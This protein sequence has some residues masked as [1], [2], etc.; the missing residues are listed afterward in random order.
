MDRTFQPT[1]ANRRATFKSLMLSGVCLAALSSS[2]IGA[3]NAAEQGSATTQSAAT[4]VQ[5]EVTI[6]GSRI[7]QPGMESPVP[8]TSVPAAQLKAMA[9]DTI[10]SGLVQLPE[11]YQSQTPNSTASWFTRGGYGN[12]DL[13]GLGI[14]RTL[15]LLNGRRVVSSTVF[16]G[17]DV[18][19]IP[20]AMISRVETVTGGASAAYGTDAVAGVVNFIL[21]TDYTGM[22]VNAQ[23][24][25][26]SRGDSANY[27]LSATFGTDIGEHAHIQ[28]SA[29]RFHQDGVFNYDGRDWYQAWGTIP[30]S[31]GMLLIR[32]NVISNNATLGGL[33]SA[34]GTVINGLQ[35][36]PDGSYSPLNRGS[37]SFGTAGTPPARSIGGSG[38]NLGGGYQTLYPDFTRQSFFGY[39]DYDV[40]PNLNIYAQYIH[41]EDST[42]RHNTPA[43]SLQG[44]PTQVT[45]F[46]DNAFLPDSL[47]QIMI[48][49]GIASF[50]LHTQ[51]ASPEMNLTDDSKMDSI[52]GGFKYTV[53]HDG[54]FDN[55]IVNGYYQ[56]GHNKRE[57]DQVGFRVD[58]IFAAAD[59]VVDPATGATVCRVS[60]FGNAFPGCQPIN[61]FGQGNASPAALDYV[62]GNDVGEQ[63]TTPLYIAGSGTSLG[64][65]DS[66]SAVEAKVNRT[67]LTQNVAELSASGTVLEGW[68]GPISA[69]FGGSYR[70]EH[71]L[72]TVRDSTNQ[73]SNFDTGHP[74]LCSGEAPGL[75]G[76][77]PP[78]CANTVGIQYSKVSNIIGTISVKELFA[79]TQI[80]LLESSGIIES[81][82][83]NLAGRWARYSGSGS[84]WAYKGGLDVQFMGGLRLRGTYSRDVR[85]ANLSERFDKTGGVNTITDPRY[86]GDGP[87]NVTIFSGGNPNVNPEAGDTFTAGAVYRPEFLP[88]LSASVDWYHIKIKDEIGQLSPQSV[89]TGCAQGAVEL[90]SFITR[91]TATDR[92]I[93]V[94]AQYINITKA[95]VSGVDL[96]LDYT[97][98]VTIFG[99]GPE[100]LGARLLTSFLSKNTQGIGSAVNIDRAGQTG[101]QE[102][103]GV[104][105]S[106]PD[107]KATGNIT[108]RNGGFEAFLQGR[109]IGSGKIENALVQGVDIESNHVSAAFYLD[110]RLSKEFEMANGQKFEVYVSGT[111]LNDQDPPITPYYSVFLGYSN[112]YNPSLFDVLGRRFNVGVT[113]RM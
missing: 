68:A 76:V 19:I 81:A 63:I 14:N 59:A 93:L 48:N 34:P 80:P 9:P 51:L 71:V 75:R 30:D 99:G 98:S 5:N 79:E 47:R 12:L 16:G 102:S 42:F 57:W 74:V 3:A 103:D 88:G 104:A 6:T 108:Y 21:N 62:V 27:K 111:N 106:L 32:P 36:N 72:Q 41:G 107:F 10:V 50:K 40:T 38:D 18:N 35:F 85:A 15:T 112:Q 23:G 61:L 20:E 101:I 1:S 78:D 65:T 13:R 100:T 54:L 53:D 86:P 94:G 28:L 105:Y 69:A 60:L 91:D 92:I 83:A 37:M 24:G 22:E 97:R 25:V 8:V 55:W 90:C 96:E 7:Q 31:S 73:S 109:Y 11:F 4:G 43:G 64:L 70:R 46:Q 39:A 87:I 26:T 67:T 84:V 29:E 89:V 82:A 17:V 44:T 49:N 77:N 2:F 56:Y 66:Y 113:F 110:L 33:I 52:T 45:I 58:R 95:V